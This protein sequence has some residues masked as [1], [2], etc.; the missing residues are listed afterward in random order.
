M[1]SCVHKRQHVRL[2]WV[3]I[4]RMLYETK[5]TA[6]FEKEE[7]MI[8]RGLFAVS[9]KDVPVKIPRMLVNKAVPAQNAMTWRSSA[10][11]G[12]A[13]QF[14]LPTLMTTHFQ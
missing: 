1:V 10:Q 13:D 9:E 7:A 12:A 6:P 8:L 11:A 14:H 4:I 5:N 3:P 2:H